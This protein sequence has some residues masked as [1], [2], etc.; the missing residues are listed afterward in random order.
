MNI[1]SYSG[2]IDA[3]R[4]IMGRRAQPYGSVIAANPS[5]AL[6]EL[7]RFMTEAHEPWFLDVEMIN[8]V[9]DDIGVIKNICKFLSHIWSDPRQNTGSERS[10]S[11]GRW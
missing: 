4:S 3:T 1:M 10:K 6:R 11:P 2:S 9:I 7:E 5:S 8:I